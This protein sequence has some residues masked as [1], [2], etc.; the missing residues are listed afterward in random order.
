[1]TTI[2]MDEC[3]NTGEDLFCFRKADRIRKVLRGLVGNDLRISHI[4]GGRR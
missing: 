2:F 4:G 3:G 1:M